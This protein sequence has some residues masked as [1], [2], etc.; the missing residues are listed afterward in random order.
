MWL[1]LHVHKM[2]H[3]FLNIKKMM[4]EE[5][6]WQASVV[7][8]FI[9][10]SFKMTKMF[11]IFSEDGFHSHTTGCEECLPCISCGGNTAHLQCWQCNVGVGVILKQSHSDE[12]KLLGYH[13]NLKLE[14]YLLRLLK[15]WIVFYGLCHLVIHIFSPKGKSFMIFVRLYNINQFGRSKVRL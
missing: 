10:W 11:L 5:F 2:Q 6:G 7:D 15:V 14:H 3:Q 4:S 1:L 12:L 9:S 8:A 13:R